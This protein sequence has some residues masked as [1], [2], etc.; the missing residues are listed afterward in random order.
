MDGDNTFVA[1]ESR[2]VG[3]VFQDFALFPHLDVR[4]N[5]EFGIADQPPAARRRLT[6]DL[7]ER[8]GLSAHGSAFPHTEWRKPSATALDR[9]FQQANC[10]VYNSV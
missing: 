3:L 10:P 8:M 5:V 4:A 9:P 7:L 6:G 1:P 2:N